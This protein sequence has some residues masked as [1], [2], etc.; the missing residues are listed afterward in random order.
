[1]KNCIVLNLSDHFTQ[2]KPYLSFSR[3]LFEEKQV[4]F[5]LQLMMGFPPKVQK[6]IRHETVNINISLR[7]H[8]FLKIIKQNL[9]ICS[10]YE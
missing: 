10:L 6:N 3:K 5:S 4:F 8:K 9:H 1:M 2:H 7:T